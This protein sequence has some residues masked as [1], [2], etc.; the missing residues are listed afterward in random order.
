M[1]EREGDGELKKL[2][3]YLHNISRKVKE[4]VRE[5]LFHI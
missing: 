5:S 4:W 2:C 3:I 1:G